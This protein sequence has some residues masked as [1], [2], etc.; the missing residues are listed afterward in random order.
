M[1]WH[2]ECDAG[3]AGVWRIAALNEAGGWKD[4]TTVED[5]DLAVRASL[6]GWKF[7][8]LSDLKVMNFVKMVVVLQNIKKSQKR[9][10]TYAYNELELD[11]L[12]YWG[13]INYLG[14]KI[15]LF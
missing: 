5:M 9:L 10:A 15:M 6:R 3:T 4:C 8:Y 7:V 2:R 13:F 14:N 11:I 1:I 12:C